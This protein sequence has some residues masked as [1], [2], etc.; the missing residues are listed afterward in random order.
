V[1]GPARMA[2]HR[3][4]HDVE[5]RTAHEPMHRVAYEAGCG[6]AHEAELRVVRRMGRR[7]EVEHTG[8]SSGGAH[9]TTG[10]P[11]S[12]WPATNAT[13]SASSGWRWREGA[14]GSRGGQCSGTRCARRPSSGGARG[15]GARRGSGQRRDEKE[16]EGTGRNG[17]AWVRWIFWK[18]LVA[19]L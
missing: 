17:S 4:A 14:R 11:S 10:R 1:R 13:P 15:G 6:L 8:Q 9:M 18:L 12:L 7:T 19:D 2:A 16:R 3:A 5:H